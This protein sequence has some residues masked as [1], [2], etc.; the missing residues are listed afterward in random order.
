MSIKNLVKRSQIFK[1]VS[2]FWI[3]KRLARGIYVESFFKQLDIL[4][5]V[6]HSDVL[7]RGVSGLGLKTDGPGPEY[8]ILRDWAVALSTLVPEH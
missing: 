8:S 2:K 7:V 1:N 4:T 6:W 5:T 3:E